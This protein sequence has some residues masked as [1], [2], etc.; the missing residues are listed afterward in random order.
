METK[1]TPRRAFPIMERWARAITAAVLEQTG[2]MKNPNPAAL[3]DWVNPD[4]TA[5]AQLDAIG[6]RADSIDPLNDIDHYLFEKEI[7]ERLAR[8]PESMMSR[9]VRAALADVRRLN[10][11]LCRLVMPMVA[12]FSAYGA[13]EDTTGGALP[14]VEHWARHAAAGV[15]NYTGMMEDAEGGTLPAGVDAD[16]AAAHVLATLAVYAA[17]VRPLSCG[18]M[19]ALAATVRACVDDGTDTAAARIGAFWDN[20]QLLNEAI[21]R[22]HAA[23]RAIS[24]AGKII[25]PAGCD[26]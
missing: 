2:I 13:D 11:V 1:Q 21:S 7:T 4:T 8:R 6:A 16:T 18:R 20:I 19:C 9:E 23:F 25:D 10:G 26:Y 3:P 17:E 22:A 14:M 5:A 12:M 24:R 15:M